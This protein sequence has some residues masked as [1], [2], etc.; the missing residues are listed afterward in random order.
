MLNT[1]ERGVRRI[2]VVVGLTT[3]AIALWQAVWRGSRRP[4]GRTTGTAARVL[5]GPVLPLFSALWLGLCVL[6]WRP[7]PVKPAKTAR[8][9][10]LVAGALLYFPGL[11]LYLWGARTLGEMY[12]PASGPGVQLNV[13]HRLITHGPFACVRHPLYLGLQIAA[14]GGLLLYRNWT[15]AFVAVNLLGLFFRARREEEALQAEFGEEWRAYARR[16]PAW[17]PRLHRR[18]GEASHTTP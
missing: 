4:A 17:M 11:A 9:A 15:L 6:L 18:T 16:V 14:F 13:G 5:R 10:A 7:L 2:G 3:L 8:V 12:R 1:V